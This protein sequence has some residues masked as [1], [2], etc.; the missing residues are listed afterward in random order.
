MLFFGGGWN[1]GSP[2]AFYP[3]SA[4]FASRGMVAIAPDYRTKSGQGTSPY[5]AVTDGKS[6]IRWVRAHAAELGIDPNR[7]AAGGGSAG[8]HLAASAGIVPGLDE[9]DEDAAISSV[10]NALVL[11]FP[12]IDTSEKG[13][14]HKRLGERW[15]EISPADHVRPALPPTII[16]HGTAD[17]IVPYQNE[18]DFTK[19]MKEAGNRSE[20]VTIEGAGHGFARL[21]QTKAANTALR[22]A[23]IFLASLG[24]LK[25]E[26]TLPPPT[27]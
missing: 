10:P 13:Y 1:G 18:V 25:G 15:K 12:V 24:Y 22:Q 23:D 17:K 19:L 4:Y 26:P 21:L 6:A 9:P 7:V 16:F 11:W 2:P 3:Q 20:L 27:R 8:G 5:D 14:G